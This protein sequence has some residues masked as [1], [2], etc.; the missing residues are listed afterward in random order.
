VIFSARTEAVRG[1][2]AGLPE[3]ALDGLPEPDARALLTMIIPHR[4]D[5]QVRDRILAEA[6]GNPLALIE[7][8][9]E[10]TEAG[11]LAGGFG[12]S[13]WVAR[14]LADRVAARYLARV[15]GLPAATRRLLLVAAAEPL[16]D[17]ALLRMAGDRLG[18]SLEDLAPAEA[19][20]LV[21]LDGH[22]TF[23]H[24]LVRSAIYR[25][26]AAADRHAVHAALADVTDPEVDQDRRAWHRAQATLGP[27]EVAAADLEQSANRALDRGGPAAAAAF[28]K[29]AAALS[30]APGEQA[31][32][33]PPADGRASRAA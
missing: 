6:A 4:L 10:V 3:I 28:L 8:A 30:P 21:R 5:E 16:G 24:P 26:A 14:P 2:L 11:S 22:V 20:G 18:L 31:R 29:R 19:D 27:D 7:F 23:R 1:E 9:R 32:G 25:S 13:P 12:V 17:P 33:C 15:N